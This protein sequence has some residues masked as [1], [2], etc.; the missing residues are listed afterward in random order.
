MLFPSIHFNEEDSIRFHG[1]FLQR[2]PDA[3]EVFQ[4]VRK[5]LGDPWTRVK[6][7]T[8]GLRGFLSR[9]QKQRSPEL[10][11]DGDALEFARLLLSHKHREP[12]LKAFF[13]A[14]KGSIDFQRSSG[15]PEL[16]NRA[17]PLEQLAENLARIGMSCSFPTAVV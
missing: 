6:K 1:L 4:E 9:F 3:D 5:H 13:F 16:A 14:W 2:F 7:A 17:M 8:G 12:E 15:N 10:L 11:S